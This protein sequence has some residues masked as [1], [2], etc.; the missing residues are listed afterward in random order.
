M[1]DRKD[2]L[3]VCRSDLSVFE[4]LHFVFFAIF[5]VQSPPS[6]FNFDLAFHTSQPSRDVATVTRRVNGIDVSSFAEELVAD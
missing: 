3:C 6:G 2:G 1:K 4:L 5:V